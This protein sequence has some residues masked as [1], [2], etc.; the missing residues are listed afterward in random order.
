[1]LWTSGTA[2]MTL[3]WAIYVDPD[4]LAQGDLGG[5]ILHE[6]VHVRQWQRFGARG[7]LWIYLKDYVSGRRGGLGHESAYLAIRFEKEARVA[8]ARY[9][10]SS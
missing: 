3:P 8:T 1:M 2:A 7:F 5:L 6:L 9:L 4:R 10:A